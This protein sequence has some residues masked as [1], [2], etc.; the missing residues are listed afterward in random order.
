M[1]DLIL[2][3]LQF[4]N[5]SQIKNVLLFGDGL[6]YKKNY[7]DLLDN[8]EYDYLLI[9]NLL[10]FSFI[11]IFF[12]RLAEH[13]TDRSAM[14]LVLLFILEL[15]YFVNLKSNYKNFYINVFVMLAN[16]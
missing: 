5:D 2:L 16:S 4:L 11:N 8:K 3:N 6:S 12:Y 9:L 14:I 1:L 7:T 10:I 15:L 13:G